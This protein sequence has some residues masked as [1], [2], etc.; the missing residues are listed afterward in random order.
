M[1]A[2][3]RLHQVSEEDVGEAAVVED[4]PDPAGSHG[5]GADVFAH[6]PR[7][8]RREWHPVLPIDSQATGARQRPDGA[9]DEL[10]GS[11]QVVR[12]ASTTEDVTLMKDHHGAQLLNA[13][14]YETPSGPAV[15][16]QV[17][18]ETS[19]AVLQLQPRAKR[20]ADGVTEAV[21]G[22]GRTGLHTEQGKILLKELPQSAGAIELML[23][24]SLTGYL[25]SHVS[26]G[27]WTSC[28]R[29]TDVFLLNLMR[30]RGSRAAAPRNGRTTKVPSL[31]LFD[32]VPGIAPQEELAVEA[33][34]VPVEGVL[35]LIVLL[36]R[37]RPDDEDRERLPLAD[38]ATPTHW[39]GPCEPHAS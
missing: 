6:E 11:R 1:H 38:G 29:L 10:G 18:V 7:T 24:S 16:R 35:L 30:G 22:L 17:R 21:R 8:G 23:D 14:A 20:A 27:S 3:S 15:A 13:N 5:T 32:P 33:E 9:S 2:L 28:N 25:A 26:A 37:W 39:V 12:R 34:R 19:L 31:C 4:V 36:A